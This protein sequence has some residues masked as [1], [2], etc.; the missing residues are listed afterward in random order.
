LVCFIELQQLSCATD[1]NSPLLTELTRLLIEEH[2]NKADHRTLIFVRTREMAVQ[3]AKYV[4]GIKCLQ[5]NNGHDIAD[6]FTGARITLSQSYNNIR[7]GANAKDTRVT[8]SDQKEVLQRFACGDTS[9]LFATTVA[10]EGIDIRACKLVIDYNV[11][12]NDIAQ[13]QRRGMNVVQIV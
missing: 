1:S 10:E 6:V 8:Q 7:I 13:V 4:N 9:I 3:L 2:Q 11:I 12:I 5:T